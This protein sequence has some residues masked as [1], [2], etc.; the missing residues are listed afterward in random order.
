MKVRT[1]PAT[2]MTT[3]R[4]VDTDTP[5]LRRRLDRLDELV[6]GPEPEAGH[7]PVRVA[8]GAVAVDDEDR[9]PVEPDRPEDPVRLAHGLVAVREERECEAALVGAEPVVALHRLRADRQHLG[10]DR[11]ELVDVGRVAVEL[12][13]AHR[14]VVARVEDEH[15]RLPL[16][17][18]QRVV[19]VPAGGAVGAGQCEVGRRAPDGDGLAHDAAST[20]SRMVSGMSKFAC[21]AWTS[22]CSSRASMSRSTFLAPSAVSSGIVVCGTMSRSEDSTPM[23]ASSRAVRTACS[24]VGGVVTRQESPS[25]TMSSAPASRAV[26]INSS[27]SADRGTR[28]VP[29]RS[30]CHATAP[31]SAIEPPFLEK[32]LRTSAPARLRLSV[33][34]STITATPPGA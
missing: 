7:R 25:S 18:R 19:A 23:P 20:V 1:A 22:S 6:G 5:R 24:S 32:M 30:N 2:P 3:N 27:S 16:E 33:S 4:R 17:V 29:L 13:R 9:A 11:P 21:T 10:V 31:G 14:G 34:T 26:S 15:D 12:P 28:M 8:H